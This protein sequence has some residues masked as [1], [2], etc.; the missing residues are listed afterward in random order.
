MTT[1]ALIG[2]PRKGG[3]TDILVEH[4][5][6]GCAEKGHAVRKLY[7]YDFDIAPCLDCRACK[8]SDLVCNLDDGMKDIYPKLEAADLIVFGTPLYWYGPTAKMKLLIDRLRPYIASRKLEGKAGL[9]V[10]PSEEGAEA[11]QGLVDMFRR[12]FHYLGMTFAGCLL[13]KAYEKGEIRKNPHEL[14]KARD[15]GASLQLG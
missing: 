5:L 1:L 6:K 9:L 4:V 7:L 8:K 14:K 10:S 13:P 12:S 3:N 2:S 11:C 15:L